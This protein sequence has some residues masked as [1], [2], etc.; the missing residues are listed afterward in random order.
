MKKPPNTINNERLSS[1]TVPARNDRHFIPRPTHRSRH[2]NSRLAGRCSPLHLCSVTLPAQHFTRRP[3]R[4]HHVRSPQV[5]QV[6]HRILHHRDS[7]WSHTIWLHH[8]GRD[9]PVSKRQQSNLDP[10]W[11]CVR[12]SSADNSLRGSNARRKKTSNPDKG[13]DKNI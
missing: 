11:C 4:V 6:R 13:D 7:G 12:P 1:K 9:Q 5:L 2:L 8:F 3:G 10:D